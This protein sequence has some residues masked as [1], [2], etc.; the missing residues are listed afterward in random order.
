MPRFSIEVSADQ[1]AQIDAGVRPMSTIPERPPGA[2]ATDPPP[3]LTPDPRAWLIAL[4]SAVEDAVSAGEDATRRPSERVLSRAEARRQLHEA[5]R[6]IEHLLSLD[7][8]G[9]L[10]RTKRAESAP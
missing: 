1:L 4:R 8:Q 7:E 5:E 3:C 6:T 10:Q 9:L 2:M